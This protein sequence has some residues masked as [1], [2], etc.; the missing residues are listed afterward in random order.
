LQFSNQ[1]NGF[2]EQSASLS[3]KTCPESGIGNILAGETTCDDIDSLK[4]SG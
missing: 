2:K 3:V 4:V 1:A